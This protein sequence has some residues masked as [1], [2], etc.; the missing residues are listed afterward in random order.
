MFYMRLGVGG[1][2][3]NVAPPFEKETIVN[4]SKRSTCLVT[5]EWKGLFNRRILT[6]GMASSD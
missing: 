5:R 1:G 4:C 3:E 6:V 2:F